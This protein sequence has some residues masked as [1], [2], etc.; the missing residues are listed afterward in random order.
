MFKN[1]LVEDDDKADL[2][3]K[4]YDEYLSV[5]DLPAEFYLQTI[6]EVFQDFSLATGT[7]VSRGRKV[8]L[9]Q[10]KHCALLGIEGEKDD[11][12]A[13]GQTK[14]SLNLC[15][16]IPESMKRYHLQEGVGHYGVFSG[17]KFRQFV[18]PVIRDFIYGVMGH[19]NEHPKTK[20]PKKK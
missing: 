15:S 6:E 19:E 8:D 2:Q 16:G 10:I 12:A 5:M 11:I 14:A 7:M 1:L 4:F 9:Q 13:V 18:V 20:N 17:S 3:K